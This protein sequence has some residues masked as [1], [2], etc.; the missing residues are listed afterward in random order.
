MK[1]KYILFITTF[2]LMMAI[3]YLAG[4]FYNV[5]FNPKEWTQESRG[6]FSVFAAP[7]SMMITALIA[8]VTD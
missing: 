4:S 8:T 2:T 6:L 7:L 3:W 5:S 1:K